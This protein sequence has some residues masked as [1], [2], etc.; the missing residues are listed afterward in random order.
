[1][2]IGPRQ[3]RIADG[4]NDYT[5]HRSQASILLSTATSTSLLHMSPE[6][7]EADLASQIASVPSLA[8]ALV[9]GTTSLVVVTEAAVTLWSDIV[10]GRSLGTWQAPAQITS[11]HINA[12]YV[13]ISTQGGVVHINKATADS[14]VQAA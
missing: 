1:V 14:L 11:A 10:T 9:P 8:A 5:H 2:D 7:R 6:I 12:G 3:V 4:I 13:A